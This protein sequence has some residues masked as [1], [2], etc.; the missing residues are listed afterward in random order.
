VI[1]KLNL[2]WV[3]TRQVVIIHNSA[4]IVNTFFRAKKNLLRENS[5][6]ITGAHRCVKNL[7]FLAIAYASTDSVGF[8]AGKMLHA[9]QEITL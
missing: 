5:L 4:L 7:V 2:F 8:S 6:Q 1:V 3:A 9:A